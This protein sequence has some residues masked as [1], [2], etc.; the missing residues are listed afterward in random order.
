MLIQNEMKE[1]LDSF[2]LTGSKKTLGQQSSGEMV[3]K[4]LEHDEQDFDNSM[5]YSQP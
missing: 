1:S 3:I 4:S 5:L 2:R